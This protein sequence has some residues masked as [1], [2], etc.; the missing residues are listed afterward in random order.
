MF[1][2]QIRKFQERLTRDYRMNQSQTFRLYHLKDDKES[3]EN[4]TRENH[5]G[6]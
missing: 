2:R 4:S 6:T 3:W 5:T 1:Q